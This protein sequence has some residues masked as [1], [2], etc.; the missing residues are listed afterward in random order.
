[1]SKDLNLCQFI[2]RLGRDPEVRHTGDGR[3]IA[4]F[5][6]ACSDDYR[7]KDGNKVEQTNWINIVAFGRLA[8]I[9]QEYVTKGS[10]IYISGK[11]I[12]RK[13]Q[14]QQGN[15]RYTTEVVAN[16]MQMLGGKGENVGGSNK[17]A[18]PSHSKAPPQPNS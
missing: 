6:I 18:K 5:S 12:T 8:E 1:M 11:Q 10:L 3:A 7:G 15:G 16:E 4:S 2:G 14:D 17:P 13:W 9:I